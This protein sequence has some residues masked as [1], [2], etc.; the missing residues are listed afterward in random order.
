MIISRKIQEFYYAKAY[1]VYL[2]CFVI[3]FFLQLFFW[4]RTEDVKAEYE[5]V[6]NVPNKYVVSVISLGDR[7]FLFRAL[8]ERLQNSGDVFAGFVAL[9]NYNY[10]LLYQWF[11]MLDGLNEK[12]N[13]IPALASYYYAQTQNTKDTIHVINYLD[14]HSSKDIDANWWW[15]YQAVMIAKKDLRDNN[16]A[17]ELAY[18]L[19]KN[20]SVKAPVW[21]KEF[22]AFIHSAMGDDCLAFKITEKVLHDNESGARK[23]D[24]TEI[25]MMDYFFNSQITKLKKQNFDPKKC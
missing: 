19:S 7:E 17:L 3:F 10:P 22:P 21:T 23:L 12:S 8:G 25:K 1:K 18:K 4:L 13:F 5:V 16:K 20:N 6:P 11:T 24:A 2:Y 15:M 14:E 9:K